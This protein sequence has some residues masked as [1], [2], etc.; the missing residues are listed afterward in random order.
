[1][2]ENRIVATAT[3]LDGE[4]RDASTTVIVSG[5]LSVGI[6]TPS[7]G[8]LYTERRVEAEVEGWATLFGQVPAGRRASH[9]DH[10]IRRVVL[11][12]GDSPP[13]ATTLENGRF[14]G[15]VML[16]QGENR[17]LATATASDGRVA[18]A[19]ITVTV[20]PQGCGELE[21]KAL[22]GGRPALS[23]S[24]RAIEIV[25]DASGSMWGQLQGTAKMAIAKDILG[26]ALDGLP[27]DLM[28]GLRVYGHQH[29]REQ[30]DCQDSELLVPLAQGNRGR[31]R[32]A[33]ASFKPR[34]QTPL[35][36]SLERVSEDFGDFQGERAAV[37]VTDGIESC[38][39]DPVAAARSL[40]AGGSFPVHVI[41]FGLAGAD[42]ADLASLR[43]IAD[44]SGGKFLTAGS[45]EE[46]RRALSVTVGTAYRVMRVSR[47]ARRRPGGRRYAGRRR[48]DPASGGRLP[49]AGR[50]RTAAPGAGPAGG[51]GEPHHAAPAGQ[52]P[53]LPVR[54][55]A[56]RRVHLL[57]GTA[58]GDDG[59]AEAGRAGRALPV[60]S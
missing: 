14:Q 44:A 19:A 3:S 26:G 21:V 22:R 12:V 50:Q 52:G 34:G 25:F 38:G 60:G 10:G 23:I 51:R 17:I 11:R 1:M 35:A 13:F 30:R 43:A 31:I 55:A 59:E 33:I 2:G 45:A 56:K 49:G 28:V 40:Q 24:E 6:D 5:P 29:P 41:G 37:L 8:T 54:A 9:T 46:L 47:D 58:P 57:R 16:H 20:R 32:A 7:D 27:D 18:D 15:R 4:T 48:G 39:G 42:D 53:G 36:Y